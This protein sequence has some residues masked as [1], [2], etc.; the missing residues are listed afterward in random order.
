M[1]SNKQT[2]DRIS[3]PLPSLS[4]A[5]RGNRGRPAAYGSSVCRQDCEI[6]PP[7]GGLVGKCWGSSPIAIA[8]AS[9]GVLA[10]QVDRGV[11]CAERVYIYVGPF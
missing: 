11:A 6:P 9:R 4:P 7:G 3:A 10:A 8:I 2:P 5:T 1:T